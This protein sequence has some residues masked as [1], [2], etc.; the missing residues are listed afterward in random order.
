MADIIIYAGN[1]DITDSLSD[2]SG[3]DIE[4]FLIEASRWLTSFR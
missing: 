1:I 2:D 3:I 4:E